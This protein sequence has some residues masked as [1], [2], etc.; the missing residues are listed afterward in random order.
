M[1]I[2][3]P[4][5]TKHSSNY[6]K[7][8]TIF[9]SAIIVRV[10]FH[11]LTNYTFDD[12]YITFRYAENIANGLGFVY[13]SGEHLLGT[14]T[15]LF[16]LM[17]A[18]LNVI[19][20]PVTTSALLISLIASGFTAVIVYLFA[21][22]IGFNK[23]S[24]IPIIV[25]I[26]FPRLLPIDTAGMETAL[27]TLMVTS[28]FYLHYRKVPVQAIGITAL[29]VLV[30]PEGLL[31]L[32]ILF[33]YGLF[34]HRKTI[35]KS[36]VISLAILLPWV[37]FATLY[38]GSPVPHSMTAKMA[39]YQHVWSSP[40]LDNLIFIMGWHNLFG[41]ILSILAAIGCW[42]L[43]K[44]HRF[45]YLE[46]VWI[47]LT[48]IALTFSS[49]LIFRWYIAPIYPIYI[50]FASATLLFLLD[51]FRSLD[52]STKL[53][54]FIIGACL[55]VALITANYPNVKNYQNESSIL[56]SIHS[57]IVTY[58]V[59]YADDNDVVCTEDIGYIGYYSNHR[60]LDRAGLVSKETVPYNKEGMYLNLII[61]H[62][63]EWLIISPSDPT[64]GFLNDKTFTTQY[65]YKQKFTYPRLTEWEF[66][67]WGLR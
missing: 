50:L 30:R 61:D 19:G 64:A 16:T 65:E 27:F 47:I 58:L 37:V 55:V 29:S 20:I 54:R 25:Y 22:E 57:D 44:K 1:V 36:I 13:N 52:L 33:L 51:K 42:Y 38:F 53:R 67:I 66:E 15:P 3:L 12:A 2:I 41:V 10:I 56:N 59:K 6:I 43:I 62:K 45:G 63:P 5:I 34:Y 21:N 7:Y 60:I 48:I 14:T 32:A 9:L 26:F 49:T 46:L 17:L 4:A 23:F 40:P 31:V 28:A 11:W 24:Y 39:L 18:G 8:L 35:L